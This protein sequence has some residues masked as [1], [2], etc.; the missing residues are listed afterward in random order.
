[1]GNIITYRQFVNEN[2]SSEILNESVISNI[3]NKF[4]NYW[5]GLSFNKKR[6]IAT[7]VGKAINA[8]SITASFG[9][10]FYV[11]FSILSDSENFKISASISW[12]INAFYFLCFL[13]QIKFNKSIRKFKVESIK[14]KVEELRAEY[15]SEWLNY[16]FIVVGNE[17]NIKKAIQKLK[18]DNV[19]TDELIHITHD[20][21]ILLDLTGQFRKSNTRVHTN[22]EVDP[23]GEEVWPEDELAMKDKKYNRNIWKI[24]PMQVIEEMFNIRF[25]SLYK[26]T[27]FYDYW[28]KPNSKLWFFRKGNPNL[29]DSYRNSLT[30]MKNQLAAQE[31]IPDNL[32]M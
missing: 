8:S 11:L 21:T 3:K 24:Y 29:E 25:R 15:D 23:Y 19:L 5:N 2:I 7:N 1:M 12:I 31:E 28:E 17:S 20:N 13:T 16:M 22:S 6:Q 18:N 30:Q 9:M 10:L 26:L 14:Q 32:N 27:D 4:Q